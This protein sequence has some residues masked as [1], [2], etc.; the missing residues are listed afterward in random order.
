MSDRAARRR[1]EIEERKQRTKEARRELRAQQEA[2]G[3]QVGG[4]PSIP[5]RMS[6]LQGVEEER[7]A[8]QQA[9]I[10]QIE[11]LRR[12]L[13]V[14]LVRLSN[15]PDPR[16][17]NKL[18]HKLTMLLVYGILC[19]VYQMASRREASRKM[20]RPMFMKNLRLF[21]PELESLPHHDTLNRVLSD[22]DVDQIEEAHID[23]IRR[24]IRKK[25]FARYL[26]ENCYPIA[27]DGTQKLVRGEL[28]SEQWQQR[29]VN[30]GEGTKMQYYVYVLEANLAFR[31]G[32]V[33]PL[34]S[35]F[36]DYTQGDTSADKQDCELKAFKR[37]AGRLKRA[38]P[39][40]PVMLLLDGLYPNGPIMAL[41]REY[42]WQFMIVLQDDSLPSI[43][44]EFYG[45]QKLEGN[46][47]F[48]MTW[49]N[50]R[51]RFR[52]VNQIG[53]EYGPNRRRKLTVHVVLC[54]ESWEEVDA[55]SGEI[56]TKSSRH[57]WLSSKPLNKGNLHERCNLGARHR[58]GI[59][60]SILA[61]KKHGYQYEHCFSENWNS[62]RG[63]HF[64]MRLG[65]AFNV[66]GRYSAALYEVVLKMGVR[67]FIEFVRET[68]AGPW[69]ESEKVHQRLAGNFQLRLE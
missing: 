26:V 65:H 5:N 7:E 42:N 8:R 27:V 38:F 9:T 6:D 68:M 31:N 15:I 29:K 17:P 66:L 43:W 11:P 58:W 67:P 35:E 48:E 55:K 63:Y 50:R 69:L 56:V 54:E 3:L 34:M 14:L 49:G 57:A 46:R 37:L 39:R 44:E 28:R 40:L 12:Y 33:I 62:M 21:F 53:Y 4:C 19:F 60:S 24:L 51:Q 2:Q 64:L 59:E 13:P 22:I 25:K 36:L 20:T 18:K 47:C 45:L 41:C 16:N 1:R 10:D 32:M 30:K 52:W 23:L 61:E